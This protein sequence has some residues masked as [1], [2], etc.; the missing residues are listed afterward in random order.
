M[1][2]GRHGEFSQNDMTKTFKYATA[3]GINAV[4]IFVKPPQQWTGRDFTEKELGV[5]HAN[6]PSDLYIC[7]HSGYFINIA[8][9][10]HKSKF[11]LLHE[12]RRCSKLGINQLVV[13]PGSSLGKSLDEGIATAIKSLQDL[14]SRWPQDVELLLETMAGQG[15][16]LSSIKSLKEV[17]AG[18]PEIPMGVCYD[19]AHS[20]GYGV[21]LLLTDEIYDPA[22]K[23]F[24]INDSEVPYNSKK[25]RH[26]SLGAGTIPMS[27]F[28]RIAQIE[29]VPFIMETPLGNEQYDL[30]VFRALAN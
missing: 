29:G 2:L 20:H 1:I 26:A 25:D 11:A 14:V 27:A 30:E 5:W 17:I 24:H 16:Y 13:H 9:G 7:A 8:G 12:A 23:L 18:V 15:S 6:K 28:K 4:A 10:E 21:N 19:T 3:M 22:I